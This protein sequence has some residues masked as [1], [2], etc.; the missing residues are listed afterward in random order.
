MRALALGLV[1]ALPQLLH[2]QQADSLERQTKAEAYYYLGVTEATNERVDEALDLMLYSHRLHPSDPEIAFSLARLYADREKIQLAISYAEQAQ[3]SVPSDKDYTLFLQRL[4]QS[5]EQSTEAIKLVTQWLEAYGEDADM[6]GA[7]S[8]LYFT[9]GQYG[10]A[11]EIFTRL[12]SLPDVSY[13]T[14]SRLTQVKAMLYKRINDPEEAFRSLEQ[15]LKAWPD[16]PQAKVSL[17]EAL[18]EGKRYAEA[19]PYLETLSP[20]RYSPAQMYG[21]W[22]EY[23]IGTQS[24]DLADQ[25]LERMRTDDE[26]ELQDKLALGFRLATSV[27]TEQG[28]P[29]RYDAFFTSLM[30]LAP[31]QSAPAMYYSMVLR[32][33]K[34]YREAIDVLHPL[35]ETAADNPDLWEALVDISIKLEDSQLIARYAV[36]AHEYHPAEW[37]YP[38]YAAIALHTTERTAEA[39]ALL[40]AALEAG[41]IS[42]GHHLSTLSG[43]L[44]DIY[45][46]MGQ[47]SK[48]HQYYELALKHSE[49]NASVLNNYAYSLVE[50]GEDL[51]KAEWLASRAMKLNSEDKNLL[52]T[53]GWIFYKKGNYSLAKL[54]IRKAINLSADEPVAVYH[55]HLGDVYMA[56]GNKDEATREW[57]RAEELCIAELRAS[58]PNEQSPRTKK[59]LSQ[60]RKKLKATK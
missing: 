5:R 22:L 51:D 16:E 4:Y 59:L 3:R 27:Q 56:E 7:L 36:Q 24:I 34:Q 21:L 9:S 57:R 53:Y 60:L 14:Y 15:Q 31:Q 55:D 41:D 28:V 58:E 40:Q 29:Q 10:Q 26:L 25:M 46:E 18:I 2:A 44:A 6:L 49:Y 39:T 20:T 43:M 52:D 48:A 11:I 33:R 45:K 37:S 54:Y 17:I 23:Y 32:S 50:E 35:T 38:F 1:C 12:Q 30:F 47:V 42:E 13:E 8:K 19:L